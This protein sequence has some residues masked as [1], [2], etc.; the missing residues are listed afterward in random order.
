MS[1]TRA[2]RDLFLFVSHVEEDRPAALKIVAELESRGVPCWIAPRDVH[3]GRAFDDEIAD[4][5]EASRAMLLIFSERCNEHEYIRRELTVAGESQKLIIPFRIEDAQPR[6]ALRVRLSDLHWIDGFVS[7]ERAIDQ[8]VSEVGLANARITVAERN[9][10]AGSGLFALKW[11]G[12]LRRRWILL[13]SL[14][15]T[16]VCWMYFELRWPNFPLGYGESLAL[17]LIVLVMVFLF[18]KIVYVTTGWRRRRR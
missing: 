7:R 18:S 12:V 10:P 2:A 15:I 3:P 16:F 5:I 1:G 8:V 4:A 11:L 13:A 14:F 17:F 9:N 6:R